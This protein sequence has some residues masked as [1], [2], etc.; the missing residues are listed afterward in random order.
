MTLVLYDDLSCDILPK[1]TIKEVDFPLNTNLLG[2][3]KSFLEEICYGVT[4]S[5][6]IQKYIEVQSSGSN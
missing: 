4:F 2:T 3:F 6:V 5:D 1:S